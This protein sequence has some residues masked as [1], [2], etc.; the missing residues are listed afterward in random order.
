MG[1]PIVSGRGL[2]PSDRRGGELVALVSEDFAARYFPG[3]S[4]I[5]RRF[6]FGTTRPPSP[7]PPWRTIVGTV[8]RLGALSTSTRELSAAA[9]LPLDQRPIRYLELVVAGAGQTAVPAATV[10]RAVADI[11]DSIVVDRVMTVDE[12]YAERVWPFRVFGGLF[13]A[14]GLAALLLAS[15]GLYGVMAFAVRRRTAEI[16]IRMA[17]GAD[18]PRIL[19]MILRQGM[20]LLAIG[21][22]LGAGLGLAVSTQ[23]TQLLYNVQPWDPSV[24]LTALAVLTLSGVTAS[25]VPA[26]RAAAV[27]P[28]VALRAE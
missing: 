8:P 7:P 12:Q 23:L 21:L 19:R 1:L 3:E 16:G 2:Q 24:L 17:L 22:V 14:F 18:E 20:V 9:I 5:G 28:L 6:R 11:D 10:R 13:S 26:R 27:D 4:A 25:L 15:A